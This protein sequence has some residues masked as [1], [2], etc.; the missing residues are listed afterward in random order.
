MQSNSLKLK[1]LVKLVDRNTVD[2][3]EFKKFFN[4][5]KFNE[6]VV[7]DLE[8]NLKYRDNFYTFKYKKN[9]LH[10][11]NVNALG[12]FRS[13]VFNNYDLLCF[14]PMK[15]LTKEDYLKNNTMEASNVEEFVEGTMINCFFDK[16]SKQ[17]DITTK[18]VVGADTKFSK[19]QEKCFKEMFDEAFQKMNLSWDMFQREHIYSFVLQHP[20]NKIVCEIKE[21]TLYLVDVFYVSNT[22]NSVQI[23]ATDYRNNNAFTR[24]L[25]HVKT[26]KHYE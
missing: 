5:D 22:M 12:L 24:L 4:S 25:Q 13:V 18:S 7:D 8:L 14:A 11:N 2:F 20:L 23:K 17:W 26:P 9:H 6:K 19:D 16:I 10:T 1:S 15:S 21:P 3:T